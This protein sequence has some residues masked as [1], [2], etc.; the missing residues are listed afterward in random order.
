MKQIFYRKDLGF[1]L[2]MFGLVFSIFSPPIYGDIQWTPPSNISV[3]GKTAIDGQV[4]IDSDD[5]VTAIWSRFNGAN[6]IVQA[7]QSKFR[8]QWLNPLD[9]SRPGR[10]AFFGKTAVDNSGNVVAIWS[11]FSGTN[12]VIQAAYKTFKSGWDNPDNIS[13]PGT[14]KN[15]ASMPQVAFDNKGNA[16][17]VWQRNDGI[18]NVIQVAIKKKGGAWSSPETLTTANLQGLGDIDPQIAIDINGNIVVVWTNDSTSTIRGVIKFAKDKKWSQSFNI[19]R[20]G[21]NVTTPQIVLDEYG[22]ATAVWA[23]NDGKNYI[24]QAATHS[25]GNAWS[26]PVDIS[27]TG[28]DALFPKITVDLNGIVSALWQRWNGSNTIVQIAS[29]QPNGKWS[30]VLDLSEL[31]QDASKPDIKAT[32]SGDLICIWKR[33]NGENFVIQV[34][35]KPFGG[36]WSSP[37]TLSEAGQDALGAQIALNNAGNATVVWQRSDAANTIIQSIF[38]VKF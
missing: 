30:P 7:A 9:L 14:A 26:I 21:N 5:N 27:K 20:S 1:A 37:Y 25:S 38:G 8:G 23:R 33:S 11:R 12:Y 18:N 15:N 29:K 13:F 3:A 32:Q 22:N 34:I 17:A 19:S 36:V 2:M 10:D 6:Y 35:S 24:V 4:V 31:G 28:Q 16:T